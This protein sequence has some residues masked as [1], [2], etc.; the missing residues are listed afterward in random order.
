M[1]MFVFRREESF[2]DRVRASFVTKAKM[3]IYT[4]AIAKVLTFLAE[5]FSTKDE[6]EW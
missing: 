3:F 1:K 6:E 4:L 2:R 5:T